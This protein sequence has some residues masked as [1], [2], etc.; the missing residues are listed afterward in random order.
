[1]YAEPIGALSPELFAQWEELH[2]ADGGL[3][4]PFLHPA[5]VRAVGQVRAGVEVGVVTSGAPSPTLQKSIGLGYVPP[6]LAD[7]GTRL[8]V[9]V[10]GR[11]VAAQ[12]VQTPFVR[13]S[14]RVVRK[15]GSRG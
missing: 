6:A 4:S 1:M 3:R 2:D 11:G 15:E 5:Y 7:P 12:V 14:V 10:R 8:E 9:M 13:G